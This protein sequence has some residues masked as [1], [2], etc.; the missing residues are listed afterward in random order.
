MTECIC[1]S[2]CIGFSVRGC[3]RKLRLLFELGFVH[4]IVVVM[5]MPELRYA[6]IGDEVN[7]VL[8]LG[9]DGRLYLTKINDLRSSV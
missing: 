5:D 3:L 6:P 1:R 7:C 4:C 8:L 9:S 2:G